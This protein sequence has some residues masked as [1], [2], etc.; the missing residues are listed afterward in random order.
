MAMRQSNDGSTTSLASAALLV[1]AYSVLTGV[2][3]YCSIKA[4]PIEHLPVYHRPTKEKGK[5][6]GS[7]VPDL[8]YRWPSV[9]VRQVHRDVSVMGMK[10]YNLPPTM[11]FMYASHHDRESLHPRHILPQTS[12]A[13][14]P[15][16]LDLAIAQRIYQRICASCSRKEPAHTQTEDR[17]RALCELI[18]GS[19]EGVNVIEH[20]SA[21]PYVQQTA[22]FVDVAAQAGKFFAAYHC[23]S[24]EVEGIGG[25]VREISLHRRGNDS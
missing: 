13:T 15:V 21:S 7:G 1:G 5:R 16:H 14:T 4:R 12:P 19:C 10:D 2:R 22:S 3:S 20:H 9:S 17:C 8:D 6:D 18:S 24:G 25:H 11:E 23:E